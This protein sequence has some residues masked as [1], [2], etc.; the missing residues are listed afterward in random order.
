MGEPSN[1]AISP[2]SWA[3]RRNCDASLF[4]LRRKYEDYFVIRR[5]QF[6]F[7]LLTNFATFDPRWD[8]ENIVTVTRD[9]LVMNTGGWISSNLMRM[10]GRWWG[11][12]VLATA[13]ASKSV[14]LCVLGVSQEEGGELLCV[15]VGIWVWLYVW[16]EVRCPYLKLRGRRQIYFSCCR[17]YLTEKGKGRYK[18]VV[19]RLPPV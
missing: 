3:T 15:G 11:G 8:R 4:C 1:I 13:W 12:T 5:T 17:K 19:Q 18:Y 16:A 10:R 2:Y 9:I 6:P 14:W 7:I